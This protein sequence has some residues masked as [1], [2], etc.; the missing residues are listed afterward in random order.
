MSMDMFASKFRSV[1]M[2]QTQIWVIFLSFLLI[3]NMTDSV[4][5]EVKKSLIDFLAKISNS[6]SQQN[7]L[8]GWNSSSDPCMDL[9]LGVAC[10]SRNISISKLFLDRSNFSGTFD[11]AI[12]CNVQPLA[13]TLTII[14]LEGNSISGGI[15]AEIANCKQLT[16]LHVS[17]NQFFGS[18]PTSL[19]M[20]SNLKRLDISNNKFS[21]KLPD[22]S[23]IS[24]LKV[25]LAQNNL[26][27]GEIPDFDFSNL[28]L[29]NVSYNNFSG[30]IPDTGGWFSADSFIS[31]PELCGDPLPKTCPP[32]HAEVKSDWNK[33]DGP[34]SNQILLYSG[35]V[36]LALALIIF[37]IFKICK[38]NSKTGKKT[39]GVPNTLAAVDYGI[40]K[41][42]VTSSE[43]KIGKSRSEYSMNSESGMIS[44]SIVVLTSPMVNDLK[45]E[46]LLR[47]PAELL[48]RGKYG[49]LYKVMLESGMTMVVKRIKD[50]SSSSDD[51][52]QRME[53]LDKV[54]HPH[55]LPVLGF[56]SSKR[57]KLLVYEYQ[58][59]GSLF[60]L[61]HGTSK[62]FDWASRLGIAATIAEALAFMHHELRKDGIGHGN[63]KS[64]N[65]LVNL[66]MEPCL[67]EYGVMALDDQESLS[68]SSSNVASSSNAFKADV[69]G[70][71]VILLELLTGKLV[72]S[73][74]IDL[75]DWVNSV[76]REEW[77]GEVF[78]RSLC[79]E[80]ASEERMVNL[81]QVAIKCVNRSLKIRP[82]MNQVAV[83]INTIKEED[84]RSLISEA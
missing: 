33:S 66:N 51:F 30:R 20:L 26:L 27:S 71:G 19:A 4:E 45:F 58:H 43:Y 14:S 41:P 7:S 1:K 18:F 32:L 40:D 49:S 11:P 17:G 34:S 35:Y 67:S 52:N 70:F 59:N 48:G 46:D 62:A 22:L 8:F 3:F 29:F 44:T 75:A 68:F 79:S 80:G 65:I 10:D 25:V 36:G 61:L 31:N 74:G 16:R 9:W 54:K 84:E 57:E 39:D 63:L 13:A 42:S 50:L 73:N 78:D 53:A 21:G 72:Q 28:D 64:S 77:T 82:S 24:G 23:R 2:N 69:Y 47:A 5:D 38:R 55:V 83:M 37:V 60:K 76:V 81:L 56:Y 12:L 15:Q 6:N